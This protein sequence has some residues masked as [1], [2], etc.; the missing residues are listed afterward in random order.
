MGLR[1]LPHIVKSRNKKFAPSNQQMLKTAQSRSRQGARTAE[2][3]TSS[4][5]RARPVNPASR[6]ESRLARLQSAHGNQHLQRLLNRGVLQAK[7]TVNQPGDVYEQ[8]ADRMADA[9]MRMP[10]PAY[11]QSVNISPA[12]PGGVQRVCSECER[13]LQRSALPIQRAC[14]KCEANSDPESDMNVRTKPASGGAPEGAP[15]TE[16]QI[17]ALRGRGESLPSSERS[18]FESRFGYDFSGVRIHTND[19]AA[20]AAD[21][22][23][24]LAFTTGRDIVFGAGQYRPGEHAGRHLMAHELTHVVQQSGTQGR[25]PS[26]I[27]RLGDPKQ[28]PASVTC[29]TPN[30]TTTTP[31][32]TSVLFPK[33]GTALTPAGIAEL[34]TVRAEWNAVPFRTARVR[35]DGFASTDGPQSINWTLSCDRAKAVASELET[36]AGGGAGIP[37]GFLDIFAQGATSEFSADPEP[38]RRVEIRA[39]LPVPVIPAAGCANPGDKR[40][41]D[42]QPVFFRTGP[43]DPSP[44]GTSWSRRLNEANRIWGKVGVFF[45][46]LPALMIDTPLKTTGGSD[47]ERAAIRGLRSGAG[48]EV[49]LVDNDVADQGGAF[50][51]YGCGASANSVMTDHGS[52]DTLLAHELG[53]TLGIRHPGDPVNPGDPNTV[54]DPTG[55]PSIPNATRNTMVNFSR[56]LCPPGTAT[57]CLHPDP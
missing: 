52:S 8:E 42:L 41:L 49:F 22:V 2:P 24:A 46:E 12:A 40:D 45:N 10:D 27:Q 9:V 39:S 18:F 26:P 6:S 17:G 14:S 37:A 44:T 47:A 33:S 54:M 7:L 30:S 34:S 56:I 16:A 20:Q 31:V 51:I 29:P 36:P 57:T 19:L 35:I 43:A 11:R 53:H 5:A 3:S 25:A 4:G 1:F 38:N 50:T 15:E 13:E 48:V 21:H 28:R 23:Q 55:S 32:L